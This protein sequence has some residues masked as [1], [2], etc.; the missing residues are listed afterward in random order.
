MKK[1][2]SLVGVDG[3]AYCIMGYVANAMRD[4]FRASRDARFGEKA[5][6]KYLEDATSSNYAHLV[7]VSCEQ[8]DKVNDFF[9]SM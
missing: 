2:Y 9:A 1:N 5:Q 7:C 6:N 4:A 3:N 8:I